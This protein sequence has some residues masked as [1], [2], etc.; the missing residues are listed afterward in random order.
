M[1][2][3]ELRQ[4]RCQPGKRDVF[5]RFM[6]ETLIPFQ[7]SKGVVVVGSF[8]D[9]EDPDGYVWIRRF[10]TEEDRERIYREMYGSD[11]WK[12]ELLPAVGELV[13]REESVISQLRPTPKSV[14]R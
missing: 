6:E 14:I 8:I 5:V 11:R 9:R 12:S 4:Y 7:I 2:L 3:F 1:L 10:D 13:Y